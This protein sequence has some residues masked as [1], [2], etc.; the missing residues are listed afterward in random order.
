[1]KKTIAVIG[2]FLLLF[3]AFYIFFII[4]NDKRLP[5]IDTSSKPD[6]IPEELYFDMTRNITGAVIDMPALSEG[7]KYLDKY[8][9]KE[10]YPALHNGPLNMHISL[11]WFP[12]KTVH[13]DCIFAPAP[14]SIEYSLKLPENPILKFDY[15]VIS[16]VNGFMMSGAEFSVVVK[17]AEGKENIVFAKH[18]EPMKPYLWNYYGTLY[19]N[20]IKYF[21]PGIEDHNGKWNYAEVNLKEYSGKTVKIIFVT[22]KDS[23]TALSFWGKP[24][25]YSKSASASKRQ[26][27]V[28]LIVID[29]FKR[30]HMIPE[31]SPVLCGMASEGVDFKR[32][33]SNGNNT[34]LSVYSFMSSR[35]SFEMPE[36]ATHYDLSKAEKESFY[37]RQIT[38]IPSMFAANGYRSAGIGSVSLF[39]DGH[40]L[41]GDIGFDEA[42][43]LEQS[44]YSPH[45]TQEAINWLAKHGNEKFFLLVY[46]YGPHGPYRPPLSYLWRTIKSGKYT[47]LRDALYSGDIIYHD[48]YIKILK[49]YLKSSPAFKDTVVVVTADHGLAFRSGVYDWPTRFGEWTKK[50]VWF[51]SHGVNVT[52]DDVNVPLIFWNIKKHKAIERKVQLL[53]LA[54]T[55]AE[56]TGIKTPP[57]FKGQSLLGLMDGKDF[58]EGVTF[59]QGVTNYGVYWKDEYLYIDNFR[60]REGFPKETVIP[61]ELYN[62]QKDPACLNNLAF[63]ESPELAKMRGF[64]DAVLAR[65][66]ENRIVYRGPKGSTANITVSAGGVIDIA[67]TKVATTSKTKRSFTAQLASGDSISFTM[68]PVQAEIQISGTIDGRQIKPSDVLY[69]SSGVAINKSLEVKPED[70]PYYKGMPESYNDDKT[71]ALLFGIFTKDN[72]SYEDLKNSPKQLKSMLEQWGYIN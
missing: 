47:N 15:G 64:L 39:C 5:D 70:R 10:D 52:P 44:G 29:S 26:P 24:C 14:A 45:V 4:P 36:T 43:N 35:Y 49:D 37:K 65:D 2:A 55:L 53:D 62:V 7:S 40:G 56:M 18:V 1:M 13:R 16:A 41:S 32:A 66:E 23:G 22:K 20:I 51:H 67:D 54:P 72:V 57:E 9:Y 19:K 27:S 71:P 63:T 8:P 3:T 60:P 61:E 25:V 17:G 50:T 12:L 34:K 59:H 21:K 11:G 30:G 33:F 31:F 42:E 48:D 38:T 46:Y 68:V 28:I 58:S 69:G 6:G